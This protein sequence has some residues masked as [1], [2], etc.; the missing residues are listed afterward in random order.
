MSDIVDRKTATELSAKCKAA[1]AALL[2]AEGFELGKVST[3]YGDS[4]SFSV[5]AIPKATNE[6]GL[7][8]NA[9]TVLDFHRYHSLFNL[10]ANALGV[11]FT[12]GR[13]TYTFEGLQMSRRKFPLAVDENGKKILLT[14]D[15]RVITAINEAAKLAAPAPA[16]TPRPR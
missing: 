14:D 15:P 5:S 8:P 10:D 1:I 12:V 7:N 4:F 11:K 2:E 16:A 9:P 13:K 3:K 6:L